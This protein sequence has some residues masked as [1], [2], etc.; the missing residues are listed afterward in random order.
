MAT[1]LMDAIIRLIPGVLGFL[2]VESVENHFMTV[3]WNI[4]S[5]QGLGNLKAF[6][7]PDVLLEGHHEKFV[8]GD[9]KCLLMRTMKHRPDL[10]ASVKADSRN[11]ADN[12]GN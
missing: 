10:M 8:S 2:T 1:A 9:E 3:S 6:E 12:K 7:V 4:P 5:I 11:E